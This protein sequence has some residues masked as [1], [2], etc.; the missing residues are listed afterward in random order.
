ML[1][2]RTRNHSSGSIYSLFSYIYFRACSSGTDRGLLVD[3]E[4]R[5]FQW[6]F[7]DDELSQVTARSHII[8]VS[9]RIRISNSGNLWAAINKLL[10]FN[11]IATIFLLFST[12]PSFL[13]FFLWKW[14][15]NTRTI[16]RKTENYWNKNLNSNRKWKSQFAFNTSQ[17]IE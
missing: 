17:L 1:W 2:E 5:R 15:F 14:P 13:L 12:F 4:W 9:A 7:S 3:N 6:N 10:L 11:N 16:R 8:H